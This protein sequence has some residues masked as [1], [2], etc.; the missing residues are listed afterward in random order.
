MITILQNID[1][2]LDLC[3]K[4]HEVLQMKRRQKRESHLPTTD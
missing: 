1:G 4:D 3:S 2:N